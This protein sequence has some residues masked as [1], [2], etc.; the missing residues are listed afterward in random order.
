MA[1][2]YTLVNKN[3][4]GPYPKSMKSN[5]S[6]KAAGNNSQFVYIPRNEK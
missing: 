6:P 2:S 1:V 4:P 3:Q 5:I